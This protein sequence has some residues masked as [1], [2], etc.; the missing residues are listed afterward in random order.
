MGQ[1]RDYS[2]E[3]DH[4]ADAVAES[5]LEVSEEDLLAEAAENGEDVQAISREVNG[6]LRATLKRFKQ[7][8]LHEA[9]RLREE[10]LKKLFEGE[11][12]LPRTPAERRGLLNSVLS[13]NPS[14][15]DAL[16]AQHRNF[17]D[18]SDE[19]VESYLK[20]LHALGAFREDDKSEPGK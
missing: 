18:L 6:V 3:L 19:D 4:L 11:C 10:K 14:L 16:T 8:K 1:P 17:H 2:K 5:L 7:R 15:G 20:Q 12:A 13:R 9:E